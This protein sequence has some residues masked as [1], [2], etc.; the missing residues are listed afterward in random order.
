MQEK[1]QSP[2]RSVPLLESRTERKISYP[3]RLHQHRRIQKAK[4]RPAS[5]QQTGADA[6]SPLRER[7]DGQTQTRQSKPANRKGKKVYTDEVIA[8]LRLIWAFFW[9]KYGKFLT[10]L[11]RRQMD[12]IALRP[13]E[14]DRHCAARC[15]KVRD[16][17]LVAGHE[18]AANCRVKQSCWITSALRASQ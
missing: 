10:P 18:R 3:E 8:S 6:R 7:Q 11:M 4:V 16:C 9:Y 17:V 12:Y 1:K 5:S 15:V 2:D 13:R 14:R